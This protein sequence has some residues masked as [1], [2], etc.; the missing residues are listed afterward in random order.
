MSGTPPADIEITVEL[1]RQLLDDQFPEFAKESLQEVGSGWDNVMFRLGDSLAV[2][3][4]RRKSFAH[5]LQNE[6]N[7]SPQL[8]LI[9]PAPV[10]I[11]RGNP[12]E[13]FPHPW[14]IVPWLTGET[15][16]LAPPHA[17]EATALANF[18]KALHQPAAENAPYNPYRGCDLSFRESKLQ[19][20][21]MNLNIFLES[22]HKTQWQKALEAP[23][24]PSKNRLWVHGDLHPQNILTQNGKI[25]AI[26]DWG[27]LT[28]GDP[29]VDAAA[30]YMLFKDPNAI[31]AY[32]TDPKTI[33]RAQGW[34]ILFATLIFANDP[35][36]TSR[37]A[38]TSLQTLKTLAKAP[39]MP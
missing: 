21:P 30:F 23:P 35:E 27:D 5:S 15:A 1:V 2:R 26:I 24:H 10:P 34:A 3:I 18:L 8:N 36:Q 16:D 17:D 12:T 14:S 39:L 20:N 6:Q 33:A 32:S 25:T 29:A 28:S 19:E 7:F 11:H 9:I 22:H 38:K 13:S 31:N 4:P 37:H